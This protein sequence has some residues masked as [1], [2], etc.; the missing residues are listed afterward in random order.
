[1][2]NPLNGINIIVIKVDDSFAQGYEWRNLPV[3]KDAAQSRGGVN[4]GVEEA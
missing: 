1:M 2:L 4:C 3:N